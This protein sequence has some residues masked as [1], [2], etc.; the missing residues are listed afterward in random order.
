MRNFSLTV[1]PQHYYGDDE[2]YPVDIANNQ[3][4]VSFASFQF[5]TETIQS[6]RNIKLP[7]GAGSYKCT[8]VDNSDTPKAENFYKDN[9]VY[10]KA[11][12][13][14]QTVG[15]ELE[16]AKIGKIRYQVVSSNNAINALKEG[17]VHYISPAMTTLNYKQ[18]TD[19][20]SQGF[21]KLSTDQLGYGYI[22]VNAKHVK[23]QNIRKAIMCAMNT[24][25][26]IGYYE[27]GTASQVVWNMSKVSWAYPTGENET[28]NGKD[29][30]Q[31][32]GFNKDFAIENIQKYM[33][34]ANVAPGSEDLK[35][36]FT[37]AGSTLQDH[38][39]YAVFRDAAALLNSLGWDVQVVCDTQALTKIATGSLEVWAAAWGSSLDPDMYQVYHKNSNAT[40]TKAWGYDYLLASGTPEENA[41]LDELADVIDA[42]RETYDQNRRSELYM[43][44]MGYILDL[45][46]E[47]PV[48]QRDVL[49]AYNANVLN[50]DSMPNK[51][52]LNP[53]SSPLDRIWEIEF[54]AN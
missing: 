54:A 18:L 33:A 6:A 15:E 5:M 44:A 3:F 34:E 17:T 46:V 51:D 4:G 13:Q 36:T 37:I 23:D 53:Y 11:N 50:A 38:P 48:Y 19:M 14:F 47:L 8:D 16:N 32:G 22:G 30:P 43:E 27:A 29:Y 21:V 12:D 52:E 10:F 20:E 25:L 39:C 24:S 31:Y 35:Y 28:Y 40:S 49:Y 42:A 41:L 7:M 45:A 26:A 2:K 9:V 1:A